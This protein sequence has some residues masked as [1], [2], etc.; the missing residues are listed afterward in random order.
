MSPKGFHRSMVIE[1]GHPFEPGQLDGFASFPWGTAMNQFR[2]VQTIDRLSERVVM[3][4][5]G[6]TTIIRKD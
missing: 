3:T 4:V 6:T 5:A 1:P 2:L